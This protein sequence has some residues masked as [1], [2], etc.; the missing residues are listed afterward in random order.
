MGGRPPPEGG[1]QPVTARYLAVQ[2]LVRQEQNGYANLVLDAELKRC[3]PPLSARD[4][5]F[6][7]GIFYTVLEH[8]RLLDWMLAQHSKRPL[9]RLDPP[10]RA[11]LRAGLAQ[12]EWMTVPLPAAVNESVK[13][14]RAFGKS[15]AA[16]MVNALLRRAAALHP[17]PA[18]WPQGEERLHVYYSLSRPIARL[19]AQQYPQDAES[20]AAAFVQR[21]PTAIRVNPLRTAD[22]ALVQ[23]LRREGYTVRQGPWPHSLLVEFSGSPAAS[24]AFGAGQFHVQGLA[25]QFAALSVQAEPGMR[26]LDLCAAPGGKS[27]T[28]GQEMQ[29]R[30]ELLCGE[31]AANRVRL[32]RQAIERCGLTCARPFH[33]DAAIPNPAFE[34]GFDRVLCDVPCSGL[35]VIGKKPDIREKTLDGLDALLDIQQKILCSGAR[36]LRPGGRLVYSTCTV[37]C[38]ENQ[39]QVRAFLQTHPDFSVQQPALSLP[40]MRRSDCGTVFLPH[41][42]GTDGFFAAV[43][44]RRQD[45]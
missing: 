9:E 14:T 37:N 38:R 8:R 43:L 7:A 25:S 44:I 39:E 5:A 29:D 24:A 23:T 28:M 27:L 16:G 1:G 18:D 17:E 15:S 22:E 21:R 42:T 4:A 6:A 13:L 2:A 19:L 41:E 31:G 26:V 45:S 32:L 12:A 36:S 33:G 34:E 30:G 20:M 3:T 11:I 35:G 40:G 10:V